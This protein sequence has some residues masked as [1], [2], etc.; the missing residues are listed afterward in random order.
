MPIKPE[1]Q[2]GDTLS[3]KRFLRPVVEGILQR[4]SVSGGRA[5]RIGTSLAIEI[6]KPLPRTTARRLLLKSVSDDYLVCRAWDGTTEGSSAIYVAKPFLLQR[7]PHDG[8][9]RHG[10]TAGNYAAYA[11]TRTVT[12]DS[13]AET[14][15]QIIVPNYQV[16]SGSYDGDEVYALLCKTGISADLPVRLIDLNVDGRAWAESD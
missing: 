11:I 9:S 13:D 1:I 5:K 4:I 3:V 8:V 6:D 12:R 10:Y 15:D 16:G 2:P 7:T 14:E